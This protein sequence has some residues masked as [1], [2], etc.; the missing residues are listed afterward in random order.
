MHFRQTT[1]LSLAG[2]GYFS[3]PDGQMG[4]VIVSGRAAIAEVAAYLQRR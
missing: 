1:V 2:T 3:I 4:G